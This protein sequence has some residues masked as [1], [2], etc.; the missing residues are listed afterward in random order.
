MT[1]SEKLRLFADWFDRRD[2][3]TMGDRPCDEV[4]R[5]L[6]RIA[7]VLDKKTDLQRFMG[8]FTSL[9]IELNPVPD[10]PGEGQYLTIGPDEGTDNCAP[11]S[12]DIVLGYDGLHARI[13]FDDKGKFLSF[14][15]WE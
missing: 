13:D 5:D 2:A 7:D 3:H 1:D 6:R 11:K 15:V 9:G 12:E 4:Q 14:G 10:H 8:L